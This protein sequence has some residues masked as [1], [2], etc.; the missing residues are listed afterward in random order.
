M[1]TTSTPAS[2]GQPGGQTA[3]AGAE[4]ADALVTSAEIAGMASPPVTEQTVANWRRRFANFP[5]PEQTLSGQPQRWRA[6]S[7]RKWLEE[8]QNERAPKVISFINLKGG[9]AKTTTSV[10]VAEILANTHGKWVLFIDL[11][12]QTNASINLTGEQKWKECNDSGRTLA[13]LY[14]DKL[15]PDEAAKFSIDDAIV[16]RVSTINGG[17]SKLHLLPSSIDLIEI[18][19]KLPFVAAQGNFETN[20]IEILHRALLP[21]IDCYDYVIIDCPPSLGIVTKNGLRFSTHYI[22]PT[23]PDILSTWGIFQIV[24]SIGRFE[25]SIKR[26]ITPLG[27]VATKVRKINLHNN[28][29]DDLKNGRLFPDNS[30]PQPPFFEAHIKENAVT[31]GGADADPHITTFNKKYGANAGAMESLTKE[32]IQRCTQ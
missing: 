3:G 24:T 20:P 8:T 2:G 18:Q 21:V 25:E 9:V 16:Q 12:P 6:S 27:I 13:Q 14:R 15:R 23:I 22:I 32:I 7:I 19:E 26:R 4:N 1:H 5:T 10:A 11:D 17:I 30:V 29:I 28:M 31:A